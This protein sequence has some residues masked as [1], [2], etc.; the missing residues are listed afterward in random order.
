MLALTGALALGTS[1]RNRYP[2][3][4]FALGWYL[5]ALFP[6]LGFFTTSTTV[7]DRYA[8]LP[9][10]SF[11]YLAAT[12]SILAL[13]KIPP[14]A[15]RSLAAAAAVALSFMTF[16]RSRVWRS[17]ETLWKDTIAVSPGAWK[18]YLN[19][20][21]HYFNRGEYERAFRFFERLAEQRQNDGLLRF[22]KAQYAL[23]QG[24]YSGAIDL[25]EGISLGGEVLVQIPL[26]LGQAYEGSGN[27]QKAIDSYTDALQKGGHARSE[28]MFT[29]RDRLEKLQAKISPRFEGQRRALQEN[30][31]DLNGRARLAIALDRAGLYEEALH[32]YSE[33]LRRGG[34]NWSLQYNMGNAYRKLGKYEE[35]ARSYEKSVSMNP[36]HPQ[37]Y[38]NLGV[39]WKMLHEYDRA[40]RAFEA[41]MRLDPNF[42]SPAFN[43][44]TLYFRLGDKENATR[45]FDRVL[46][47]FP[48]LQSQANPYLEAME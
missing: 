15:I 6:V 1:L 14:I 2:E 40:I 30:P 45:A 43:L 10:Y 19:L 22:V 26:L 29:A 36:D 38:N 4:L 46:R 34:D 27:I 44:A 17:D 20:G 11:V 41:A 48:E 13:S 35:A 7:A 18:A 42:K 31:S 47:S 8:Y 21:A 16:E 28:A 9:S 12:T 25:L 3:L 23:Q 24:N 39:T 32:H 33:L 5:V 37:T